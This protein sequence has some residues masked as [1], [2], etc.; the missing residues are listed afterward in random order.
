[1]LASGFQ[2]FKFYSMNNKSKGSNKGLVKFYGYNSRT[3]SENYLFTF[4]CSTIEAARRCVAKFPQV[5][6]A[7][8]VQNDQRGKGTFQIRKFNL[9]TKEFDNV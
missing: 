2:T 3:G 6:A 7:Y 4:K 1:M 8:F 9:R 5:K